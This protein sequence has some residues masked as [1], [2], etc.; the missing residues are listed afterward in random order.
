M[1]ESYFFVIFLI[2]IQ[3]TILIWYARE[4]LLYGC[5]WEEVDKR[6]LQA[7]II[8]FINSCP[9]NCLELM[10]KI[11]SGESLS[12]V[13]K[14]FL[15]ESILFH[16]RSFKFLERKLLYSAFYTK[17]RLDLKKIKSYMRNR[18]ITSHMAKT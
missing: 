11:K 16:I 7:V 1:I 14:S 6:K 2:T 17:N 3:L 12:N 18:K 9:G 13:D 4:L 5:G 10:R 15:R 8:G